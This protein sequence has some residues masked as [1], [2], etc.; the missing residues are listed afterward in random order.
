MNKLEILNYRYVASLDAHKRTYTAKI[1]DTK[2]DKVLFHSGIIGD[3][4]EVIKRFELLK[5]TKTD[6]MVIYEAGCI[7]YY[8]FKIL[9]S[10][11]YQCL[12]IAPSSIPRNNSKKKTDKKDCAKNLQYHLSGLLSYVNVPDEKTEH[13]RELNR[14]RDGLVDRIRKQKQLITAFTLRHGHIFTGTKNEWSVA[15]IKWLKGLKFPEPLQSVFCNLF[16]EFESIK[17]RLTKVE[18]ELENQV[19]LNPEIS[20]RVYAYKILP[21]FGKIVATTIAL[22]C[23][24]FKRFKRPINVPS[25]LG[26]VPGKQQSDKSDPAL[27]ITKEG[28]E[29]ARRMFITASKMYGDRRCLYSEKEINAM[30]PIL[31]SFLKKIQDRLNERY[32]YLKSRGKHVNKVRCAIARE[33]SMFLWE[34]TI[35]IIPHIDSEVVL[36]LAA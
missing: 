30:P 14:Y 1:V 17:E 11:G 36:K 33:M 8:P 16:E 6:T 29:L 10:K 4:N 18:K 3:I 25:F 12:I 2:T 15:H 7:G 28:N 34:Y 20:N 22:E 27:A 19:K 13:L 23:G 9:K 32:R 35:D 5:L 24:D 21:G 26:L 31:K